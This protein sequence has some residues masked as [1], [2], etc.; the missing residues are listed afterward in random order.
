MLVHLLSPSRESFGAMGDTGILTLYGPLRN[1]RLVTFEPSG[2]CNRIQTLAEANFDENRMRQRGEDEEER[3]HGG[4]ARRAK[5][6]RYGSTS[7]RN[8]SASPSLRRGTPK[9]RSA[10]T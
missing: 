8:R 7:K 6:T 3:F 1:D 2:F 5:S 4:S 10:R 9:T